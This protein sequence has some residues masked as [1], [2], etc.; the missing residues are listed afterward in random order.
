MKNYLESAL[1]KKLMKYL[2]AIHEIYQPQKLFTLIEDRERYQ[3]YK[4]AL[5]SA[6]EK[7]T[8]AHVLQTEHGSI[9]LSMEAVRLGAQRVIHCEPWDS[10]ASL[11][12][13]I[14]A[15]NGLEERIVIVRKRLIELNADDPILE[16][17]PDIL[18]CHNIDAGLVG[19]GLLNTLTH[20]WEH[21]LPENAQVIPKHATV[22]SCPL[23]LLTHEV[24]G[25]DLSE[26]NRYRWSLFY[27][28]VR[29]GEEPYLQ[30]AEPQPCLELDFSSVPS[31]KNRTLHFLCHHNAIC[32]AV[33][34]WLELDLDDQHRLMTAAPTPATSSWH[35]A[36]QYLDK[37]LRAAQN[38][39]LTLLAAIE[40]D[41]LR[42]CQPDVG[43]LPPPLRLKPVIAHWHFPMLA[44]QHR[45]T[46]YEQA[47]SRAIQHHPASHVLDIGTGAGLLAMMAARAGA[48]NI[49]AC[50]RIPHM[51]EI[52]RRHFEKNGFGNHIHVVNKES[53]DLKIPDDMA[54][55]ANILVSE[56]VDHSLLGEGFL[57][58]LID[59]RSRLMND[60]SLAI[61]PSSATVFAMAIDLRVD[62]VEGFD[63]NALNLFRRRHYQGIRLKETNYRAL[64]EPFETFRFNF[65]DC[66]FEPRL[67][68]FIVP[69]T[70]DGICNAIAFWYHL[71]LDEET[72]ISTAPDSDISAWEQALIFLD[73][74][75]PV[76][77]GQDLPITGQHD[78]TR[79]QFFIEPLSYI[80]EGGHTL[81]Q[82]IP[83][84]FKELTQKEEDMSGYTHAIHEYI[85]EEYAFVT[86]STF[87][88]LITSCTRLGFDLHVF[89]DF[90]TQ[91]YY[92]A[93]GSILKADYGKR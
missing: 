4:N 3:A 84:W 21:V 10:L 64:T 48:K 54:A 46:A 34:F 18:I 27:E 91:I 63:L 93:G 57:P 20:A 22:Q 42:F 31:L 62:T 85:Q 83:E 47:I 40:P 82:H 23:E 41:G 29:L 11:Y 76:K 17:T 59:A 69:A 38:T 89:S 36:V 39:T 55:R 26:F 81:P 65:Y 56:T 61:I 28:N 60:G 73:Q 44:D 2:N 13:T 90:I 72:V 32:N 88:Q 67:Q 7:K 51:A 86:K 80:L 58:S 75:F 68:H 14:L 87:E 6:L 52:A 9:V 35:Q 77:K 49:T 71:Y 70:R 78:L 8:H 12:E 30:L 53:T 25:F 33:G 74:E 15:R 16:Q 37:P 24:D 19:S 5:K 50:E 43:S 45:N 1:G 79:L 92:T 66:S